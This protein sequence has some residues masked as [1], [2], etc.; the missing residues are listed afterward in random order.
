M[1]EG[2]L[3]SAPGQLRDR[4]AN[5]RTLLAWVRT[6]LALMGF[7]LLVAKFSHF[8]GA[9]PA[10]GAGEQGLAHALGVAM[11][12]AGAGVMTLGGRRSR[13]YARIIDPAGQRPGDRPLTLTVALVAG[14]GLLLALYLVLTGP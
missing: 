7:G 3:A 2:P 12:C 8:P 11:V 10:T 14:L 1:S 6:A 9:S 5:E 4:L 13:V